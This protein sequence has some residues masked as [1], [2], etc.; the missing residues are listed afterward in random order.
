M[1][2]L[3]RDGGFEDGMVLIRQSDAGRHW[4]IGFRDDERPRQEILEP[5]QLARGREIPASLL[6]GVA[7]GVSG[8]N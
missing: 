3:R 8:V 7:G 5:G 2:R 1:R 4:R 6:G